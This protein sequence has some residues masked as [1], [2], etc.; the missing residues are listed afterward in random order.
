MPTNRFYNYI[1]QNYNSMYVPYPI[2]DIQRAGMVKEEQ[3]AQ[4]EQLKSS[5]PDAVAKAIPAIT[6][7][8][9]AYK[10]QKVKEYSDKV[11][12]IHSEFLK[13]DP[14]MALPQLKLLS[15][16]IQRD[17]SQD[18]HIQAIIDNAPGYRSELDKADKLHLVYV[19]KGDNPL[20]GSY[21][22]NNIMNTSS[23]ENGQKNNV[24]PTAFVT[25]MNMAD[26]AAAIAKSLGTYGSETNL[27]KYKLR[28]G[29][30]V[31]MNQTSKGQR[32]FRNGVDISDQVIEDI[33]LLR[34]KPGTIDG[35]VSI[36]IRE[37]DNN[38]NIFDQ[39]K[40]FAVD[41]PIG[42]IVGITEENEI[43]LYAGSS[44]QSSDYADLNNSEIT[45]LIQYDYNGEKIILGNKDDSVFAHYEI[46]GQL[47]AIKY[48][49][50][51]YNINS[52]RSSNLALIGNMSSNLDSDLD[53][54][55]KTIGGVLDFFINGKNFSKSF[56][57]RELNAPV[58]INLDNEGDVID[59]IE[60]KWQRDFNLKYFSV[61]PI[62]YEGYTKI[63]LPLAEATHSINDDIMNQL[64]YVDNYNASLDS[65]ATINLWFNNINPPQ[66]GMIRDYVFET[67]GRSIFN[68]EDSGP[69]NLVNN[70]NSS[71]STSFDYKLF[72]N[73]P[74][75]F[76]PVTN[77]KYQIAKEG[78]TKIMIF[79]NL[80][81]LVKVLVD[82]FKS[83]GSYEIYFDG[84]NFASGVYYYRIEVN[85]FFAINKMLLIK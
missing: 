81:Q 26:K 52:R 8:D 40:L 32:V 11:D 56:A 5:L 48:F 14:A 59:H 12:A 69:D 55:R 37:N 66:S 79:N 20:K 65:S 51:K 44:V 6:N 23:F 46:Q 2:E 1:P 58:I 33:Y 50:D 62:M 80:G 84:S 49:N 53:V 42:T 22:K 63:E 28:D 64:M 31:Y 60:I 13:N 67:N 74:N 9:V 71:T 21:Y 43:V 17:L 38:V 45:E 83:P 47:N 25:P 19:E 10:N 73:Y 72:S 82:E 27:D 3:L 30:T 41:H 36:Y 35:K 16:Q 7:P 15:S 4:E 75:P 70:S 61:T 18:P 68:G 78:I 57:R 24:Q 85:N 34:I 54:D 39:I 76:N 77:I 29:D